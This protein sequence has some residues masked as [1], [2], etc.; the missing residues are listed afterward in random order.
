MEEDAINAYEMIRESLK[1]KK[2]AEGFMDI[3]TTSML[4]EPGL[5]T[6]ENILYIID[7]RKCRHPKLAKESGRQLLRS[8]LD[9]AQQF[10]QDDPIL[11]SHYY[12]MKFGWDEESAM[13]APSDLI[14]HF[15]HLSY[16]Y[17][18]CYWLR[19]HVSA[20]NKLFH[21]LQKN[22]AAAKEAEKK[23][24]PLAQELSDDVDY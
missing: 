24:S 15:L 8:E 12:Y 20:A 23:T 17:Q 13:Y 5:T 18:L 19:D 10:T 4:I 22:L 7:D 14:G 11:I 9:L 16:A 21:D 3:V 6:M 1:S 2:D